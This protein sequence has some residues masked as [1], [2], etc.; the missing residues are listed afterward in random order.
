MAYGN[1]IS[2][3]PPL[4]IFITCCQLTNFGKT[5]FFINEFDRTN[6]SFDSKLT[7]PHFDINCS[8][9]FMTQHWEKKFI[10]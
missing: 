10:Q 9:N 2:I 4:L 5:N 1:V 6:D 7:I 8:G 3:L